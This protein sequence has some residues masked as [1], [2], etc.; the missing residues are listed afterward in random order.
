MASLDTNTLRMNIG[1]LAKIKNAA[2]E[3]AESKLQSEKNEFLNEFE[4][5]PVTEEIKAGPNSKN[6]SMTLG[7][8]GNLFSF[9]GFENNFD[10]TSPVSFLIRK[11]RLIKTSLSKK[12]KNGSVVSFRVL[13]PSLEDF[14]KNSPMPWAAG[15]SWLEGVERGISG[16]G[17][18]I[19][20]A[21]SGRSGGGVQ[22]NN[23]IRSGAFKN[24][25]YF[26]RMYKNFINRINSQ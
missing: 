12:S 16:F 10:P 25:S 17:Y 26:T 9:I 8:Y 23:Q 20:R 6:I 1:R 2:L 22:A 13:V 7:G 21:L 15:R 14:R 4:N 11:I 3:L 18:Y 19:S 5:H 24:T